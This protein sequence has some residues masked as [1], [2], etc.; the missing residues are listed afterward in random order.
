[1]I[2]RPDPIFGGYLAWIS[3][4]AAALATAYIIWSFGF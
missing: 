2:G 3:I 1:V 4:V